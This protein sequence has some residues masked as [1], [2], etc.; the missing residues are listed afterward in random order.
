MK[1]GATATE[2]KKREKGLRRSFQARDRTD[3]TDI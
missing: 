1:E 3:V 2:V